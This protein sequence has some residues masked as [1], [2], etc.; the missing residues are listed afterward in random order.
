MDNKDVIKAMCD[1]KLESLKP[2]FVELDKIAKQF[3]TDA[4]ILSFPQYGPIENKLVGMYTF[5]NSVY[6]E[7][8]AITDTYS[9]QRFNQLKVKAEIDSVK[10]V[11][12]VAKH[13]AA[14]YTSDLR[15]T[16]AIL[17]GRVN[18]IEQLLTT[19]RRHLYVDR[20][21]HSYEKR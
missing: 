9:A 11:A 18:D 15:L 16:T 17:E 20:K 3:Y 6:K 12:D 14:E 4:D 2:Y 10:F 8:D 13:D 7:M 5:I 19:C 1:A 21:E